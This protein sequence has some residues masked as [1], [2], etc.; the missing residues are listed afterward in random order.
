MTVAET[1][2]S[3]FPTH[4]LANGLR[5]VAQPMS[6]VESLAVGLCVATG[7][8]DEQPELAGITHFID[9]LAFQGTERHSVR[10]LT[11]AFEDLGAR[12]DA[13]AGTELTWY[14]ALALGRDLD[15]LVPL[16]VEVCRYPLFDP[17]ET[18]KVR[19]RQLQELAGL[20]DEPMQKVLDVLQR[21]FFLGHP[22]GNS[23]LGEVDAVKAISVQDLK[24]CWQGT[25]HPNN[26]I[27][28]A[29]GKLEFSHLVRA[30]ESA[31]GDWPSGE[32]SQ[33]PDP[34]AMSHALE[35]SSET[36]ISSISAS[37]CKVCRSAMQTI[38]PLPCSRRFLVAP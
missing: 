29:A 2:Q 32:V 38:T 14:T 27:F 16:I 1:T 15:R 26:T 23:V 3:P 30:V 9:G 31:C 7:S 21:E 11:E 13:S 34:P 6:G 5:I 35:F 37:A 25:H 24:A 36:A 12:Y 10:D 33:L 20:E 19:D 18:E 8:K 22:Y 17:E 4:V 28:A